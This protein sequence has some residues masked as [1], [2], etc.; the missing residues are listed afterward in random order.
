LAL[1]QTGAAVEAGTLLNGL[2][3]NLASDERTVTARARLGFAV[4][5]QD[6]PPAEVLEAAIASDPADLRARHLLGVRVLVARDAEAGLT[7][8]IQMLQRGPEAMGSLQNDPHTS[9]RFPALR[10]DDV[11]PLHASNADRRR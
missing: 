10:S 5:L 9:R 4:L 2:P 11:L 7:K 6:A 3:A 8:F 1:P